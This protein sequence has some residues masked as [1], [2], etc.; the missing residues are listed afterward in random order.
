[1]Y[2]KR[3]YTK[4][5]SRHNFPS[6]CVCD[7]GELCSI[8]LKKSEDLLKSR[9]GAIVTLVVRMTRKETHIFISL[10]NS[11]STHIPRLRQKGRSPLVPSAPSSFPI[12]QLLLYRI[13]FRMKTKRK[14]QTRK[15]TMARKPPELGLGSHHVFV[16]FF[17]EKGFSNKSLRIGSRY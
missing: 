3:F 7:T 4:R 11:I 9:N 15:N 2:P 6:D 1:M 13:N 12:L 5:H 16:L 10:C 17:P 8:W 14:W